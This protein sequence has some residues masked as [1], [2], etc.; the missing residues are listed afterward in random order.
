MWPQTGPCATKPSYVAGSTQGSP[1]ATTPK[2]K[3][4]GLE[5]RGDERNTARGKWLRVWPLLTR[6]S[7]KEEGKS[8]R[9]SWASVSSSESEVAFR[10]PVRLQR[11]PHFAWLPFLLLSLSSR[12]PAEGLKNQRVL[13]LSHF[14]SP[15]FYFGMKKTSPGDKKR[16]CLLFDWSQAM[17]PT[18]LRRQLYPTLFF[19]LCVS[20]AYSYHIHVPPA[21]FLKA[22]Y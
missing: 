15:A 16:Y 9:T 21:H 12:K 1:P 10:V 3:T 2:S 4:F 11:P 22:K 14:L 17:T 19:Q 20:T 8:L 18:P 5:K 7:W 6:N 13:F